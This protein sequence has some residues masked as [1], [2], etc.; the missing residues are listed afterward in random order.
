MKNGVAACRMTRRNTCQRSQPKARAVSM[1]DAGTF[2]TP[3]WALMITG[4]TATSQVRKTLASKPSP[5]Q[6]ITSGTS[7][8]VGMA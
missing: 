7:A 3:I 1:K 4:N 5:S 8:T 2:I 6:M